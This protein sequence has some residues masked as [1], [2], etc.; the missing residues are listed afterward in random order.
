[1]KLFLNALLA[2][3]LGLAA[4]AQNEPNQ[5]AQP[6]PVQ[7]EVAPP[8]DDDT[9]PPAD[10]PA[11]LPG[12]QPT[13]KP[14]VI[15]APVQNP[16][17]PAATNAAPATTPRV[18]AIPRQFPRPLSTATNATAQPTAPPAFPTLP[19]PRPRAAGQPGGAVPAAAGGAAE[20]VVEM[21][22]DGTDVISLKNMPIEQFLGEYQGVAQRIVLRGQNLP[23][24]GQINLSIPEG[25]VLTREERLQMYDTIL[26]LNGV[27]MIP[28]GTKAVLAVPSAQSL[29]EGAAFSDKSAK[30]YAEASQF[31]THVVQLKFADMQEAVDTIKGFA[32]NPN[33]ILGIPTTKTIVLRDYAINVKRMLEVLEKIDIE[34]DQDFVFEVIPIRYGK[35][36]EVYATVSSVTGGGGGGGF[37]GSGTTGTTGRAGRF[38]TGGVGGG[39]GRFGSQSSRSSRNSRSGIYGGNQFNQQQFNQGTAI[40]NQPGG[41]TFQNRLN[42]VGRGAGGGG[43]AGS[44]LLGD[45]EITPDMRSNSL[46]VYGTKKDIAQLKKVL[47]KVDTLL[48]QVLIE[49]VIM[50]VTLSD[51]LNYGLT[52]GQRPKSLGGSAVGGGAI[53]NGNNSLGAINGFLGGATNFAASDGL[54]YFTR[55]NQTWDATLTALA[56][57]GKANIIQRPR[58]LTSHAVPASFFVGSTVPFISG[59]YFGVTGS[60]SSSYYDRQDVG[61][62]LEVTP[63]ITPDKLVVMEITQTIEELVGDPPTDANDP[64]PSTAKREATSQLSVRSGDA[65][66]LGGFMRNDSRTSH[67]GVPFLKDIPVLG[68]LFKSHNSSKSRSELMVLIKPTVLSSPEEAAKLADA[69]RVDSP[70]IRELEKDFELQDAAL[71]KKVNRKTGKGSKGKSVTDDPPK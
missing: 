8:A 49:G 29:Q 47:E 56:D 10:T 28:T 62:G 14:A 30:D 52:V 48:A 66:L 40:Q 6:V 20:P 51:G 35:V 59:S 1:V 70:A 54:T 2:G 65:V 68:Y 53:N 3:L 27:T 9:T 26:A 19:A 7:P 63:F 60:G 21:S 58:I 55:L 11:P 71:Q 12:A 64:P 31:V 33:G 61:I 46:I 22:E 25:L 45:L 36:E 16:V 41:Q 32:K 69:Q 37:I 15:P 39:T 24:Q 57:D 67:S 44:Y 5:P 50:D 34:V 43:G 17:V 13:T 18:P 4:V 38:G 23:L 42:Q